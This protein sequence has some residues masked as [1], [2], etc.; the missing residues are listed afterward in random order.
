[1]IHINIS[2]KNQERNLK[3]Q[4]VK[5]VAKYK[6]LN[7][8]SKKKMINLVMNIILKMILMMNLTKKV[9]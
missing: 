6:L 7:K 2:N 8:M 4:K 5:I 3:N 1:M 9:K